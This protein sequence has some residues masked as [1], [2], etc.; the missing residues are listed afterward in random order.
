MFASIKPINGA[1]LSNLVKDNIKRE[2]KKYSVGG[3]ELEITDLKYLYIEVLSNVYYDGNKISS[4][5]EVNHLYLITL[6][7]MPTQLN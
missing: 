2:I 4:G 5:D 3:V 7:D 6:I 1:Y